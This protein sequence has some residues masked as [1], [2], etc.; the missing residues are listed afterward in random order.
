MRLLLLPSVLAV[1]PF[2]ALAAEAPDAR[3]A[4]FFTKK[5]EPILREA[6]YKC[7]SHSSDK[8][9]GGLVLDSRDAVLTG[10]D[11]GAAV[12][13]GDPAKSLLIEAVAYKNED[14]QMPPKGKKLP[15][16]QIALLTEWVKMGAPWPEEGGQKMT[17][18][19]KGKITDEDR[20]WWAF[21]PVA[22]VEPPPFEGAAHPLD[23][24]IFHRLQ[25]EGLQPAPPA[26]PEKLVRRLYFDL[27]GLPPTPDEVRDFTQ[28]ALR[29]PQSAI[30]ALTDRLLASPRYGERW[31]RHWLDLV[32][33]AESDGYRVDDYRPNAWRYRDYVIRALNADK[34]YDRFVQEQLAGDELWPDDPEARTATGYLTHG[35]YEYNNRDVAGQWSTMLNDLTDTTADVFLGMGVQCARCHDHKFDPILQKDY[36][37]LQAFFAPIQYYGQSE[38]ATPEQ[39][40]AYAQKLAHWEEKTADLRR[41]IEEIEVKYRASGEKDAIEKFPPETRALIAK[42]LAERTPYEQQLVTLAWRQVEYEW[43]EKRFPGRVKEP[44][45]SR[46]SALLEQLQKFAADCPEPL[47][48]AQSASD[49]GPI[50]PPV[51]IPKKAAL[52]EIAPGFLSALDEAPAK[53]EPGSA[54]TTG[55]RAALAL[56]LTQPQNPLAARVIVNRVWQYHFG[57]GLAVNAS[58]F[59]KLGEK[60]SHPELLD[61]LAGWF[62][63]QGWSL[64]KLHRLIVTSATY[65]QSVSN[66]IAEKARLKDPEN[67]L[68]WRASTKRLDAEQIRDAV[69]A[70]TGEIQ[71]REGGAGADP[72]KPVRT[73]YNKVVRNTR[74]PMLEVFD[75]PEGFASTSLR[76]VTTTPTQSLLMI[77][78]RWSL[79]R[80]GAFA[81]RLR[82]ESSSDEDKLVADAFRL[83]F[84]REAT[85]A[86]RAAARE[87]IG[88]QSNVVSTAA[89]VADAVPFAS[90]KMQFRDGHAA[91]LTPGSEQERLV[92]AADAVFPKG[93]FTVEAF[94]NLRTI[95]E[96]GA[97]R[98][99][100]SKWDG[101]RGH[102]GWSLGVTG[103]GSRHKPQ[104]LVLQICGDKPW[105]ETDPVEPVFSGLHIE[106]GRPYFVAVA[107][108]LEDATEK[109][110]TFYA[111]DL[112]N[113]DEPLQVV[114]VTHATTSGLASDSPLVIGGAPTGS[115]SLFDGL[116]DDVRLSSIPLR[117]EQL[118]FTSASIG[119]HTVGYWKFDADPGP[120]ADSSGRGNSIAAPKP[121]GPHEDPRQ[122]ALIDFCH[123]LLNSNEFLYVD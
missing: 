82:K 64:K 59:G 73:I 48:V 42:P 76:N 66:P 70:L 43:S 20:Q 16:D 112:S 54:Q 71:F 110:V 10:G 2:S 89:P 30:G 121:S 36:F 78:S 44:D 88:R 61:W 56:W 120:Y 106:L 119:E 104:T 122:L 98:T 11:T 74:D 83:A 96:A 7:H 84:S 51:T 90:E 109:G 8:I 87:F 4:E 18:R 93:D 101:K 1:F 75:V 38:V 3:G 23:R 28:S 94:I 17:K 40:A 39:R 81:A 102:P 47:P 37:R 80:A 41:Q 69:L 68:L 116:I 99:I 52:G 34:P 14:L 58:D 115:G 65:R 103:K 97:V 5:I 95:F 79:D 25:A 111:K 86:E 105:R 32:R 6:C 29:D 33:Y 117:A 92:I 60:P 57:A 107:V 108:D 53:I 72:S 100:V 113:D 55:R 63:E 123:V 114:R 31:A 12:V 91:I 13:P 49:I 46:R 67:R 22:K 45:K 21:R 77:N 9:K 118:L 85:R 62:V 24:F 27:I 19:A 50:A 26:P 15:D 35:I